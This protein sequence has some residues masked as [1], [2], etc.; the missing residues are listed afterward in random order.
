MENLFYGAAVVFTF[1]AAA[2]HLYICYLELFQFGSPKFQQTFKTKA[3]HYNLLRAPFQNLGVYNGAIG[4]LT[5]IGLGL[6]LMASHGGG[7]RHILLIGPSLGMI[8]FGLCVMSIAGNYLF[9]TAPD[10][11]RAAL[12]QATPPLLALC[13]WLVVLS[14]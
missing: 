3:E 4:L 11:R 1:I 5:L 14:Y 10:K 8:V 7:F 2:I 13:A 12:I 9:L 6:F